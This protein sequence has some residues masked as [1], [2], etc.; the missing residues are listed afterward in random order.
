MS[1]YKIVKKSTKKKIGRKKYTIDGFEMSPKLKKHK[2]TIDIDKVVV[3]NKEMQELSIKQQFQITY[4]KLF[5]IVMELLET[6]SS[7]GDIKLALNEVEK[8]KRIIKN[9]YQK[10]LMEKEY[11]RMWNKT[12]LLEKQLKE[13]L[14]LI[15]LFM[16]P[17]SRKGKGR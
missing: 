1:E 14:L 5:R 6:D 11:I 12:L 2:S 10:V 8:M 16:A 15:E 17:E 9:K 4:R 3:V 7:E 13:R